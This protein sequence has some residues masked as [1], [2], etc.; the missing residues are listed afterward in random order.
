VKNLPAVQD[1]AGD[2]TGALDHSESY[3]P[4][5]PVATPLAPRAVDRRRIELGV[6]TIMDGIGMDP[7]GPGLRDTPARVARMYEELCSGLTA[8]PFALLNVELETAH[9]ELVLVRDISFVSL[10]E[11]HLLPV[12][13]KAHVGYLPGPAGRITGLSKLARLID[14]LARRPTLQERLTAQAADALQEGLD[15][16]GAIVV[17]EAEHQCMTIRGVQKLGAITTT[18]AA[19]GVFQRDDELRRE[20]LSLLLR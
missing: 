1:G 2:G 7:N 5:E 3:A 15:A 4:M 10:C 20:A 17:I 14:A 19:R 18:T 6:R 11:H 8:D 16:S 12:V 13:G 9:D